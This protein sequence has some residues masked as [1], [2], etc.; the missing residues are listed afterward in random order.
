MEDIYLWLKEEALH[1]KIA[2][3][4]EV[5]PMEDISKKLII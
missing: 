2:P 3:A 4:T 5:G 1:S